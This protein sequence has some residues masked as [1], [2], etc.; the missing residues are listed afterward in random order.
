MAVLDSTRILKNCQLCHHKQ[1]FGLD[2]LWTFFAT[3]H[4]KSPCDGIGG[5][6]AKRSLQ[7]SLKDQ[8]LDYKSVLDVCRTD[9]TRIHFFNISQVRMTTVRESLVKRF[10]EGKTI[11][12]T[13]SS[14]HFIPVSTSKISHQLTSEDTDVVGTFDFDNG[15]ESNIVTPYSGVVC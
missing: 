12:G 3:S 5:F 7:K 8:I 15:D 4:G 13:R 11:P 2:A 1:D 14:H 9:L 6:V 10:K